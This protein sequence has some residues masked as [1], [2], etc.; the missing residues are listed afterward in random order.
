MRIGLSWQC[1]LYW[2]L[3]LETMYFAYIAQIVDIERANNA[4]RTITII[5]ELSV[6][7]SFIVNSLILI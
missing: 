2:L 5:G 4:K 6:S 7:L 3:I 1:F